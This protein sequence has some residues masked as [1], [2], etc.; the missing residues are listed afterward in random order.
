M[1]KIT[2]AIVIIIM[3]VLMY[4]EPT[5]STYTMGG[6]PYNIELAED[7]TILV[8]V[9]DNG[10]LTSSPSVILKKGD[11]APFRAYLSALKD[12]HTEWAKAAKEN[13]ITKLSKP[14][15]ITPGSPMVEMLWKYGN[16]WCFSSGDVAMSAMF[17][18]ND[19]QIYSTLYIPIVT[20]WDNEFMEFDQRVLMIFLSPSDIQGLCDALDNKHVIAHQQ[21]Q[22]KQKR[23]FK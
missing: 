9:I 2:I 7:G 23:L 10:A 11:I 17:T 16:K 6:E 1:K 5:I 21:E 13:N 4:A 18:I 20:A 15:D 14:M 12:K 22:E 19:G 8:G 3:S